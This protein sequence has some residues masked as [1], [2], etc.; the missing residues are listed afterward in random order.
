[1][2][3]NLVYVSQYSTIQ[4]SGPLFISAGPTVWWEGYT[5]GICLSVTSEITPDIRARACRC[6]SSST[7][8][9][10]IH[11]LWIELAFHILTDI[12]VFA[13]QST[14]Y[15]YLDS[16][17]C[18]F[19]EDFWPMTFA[20]LTGPQFFTTPQTP[21]ERFYR[22]SHVRL[23]AISSIVK[24]RR[25]SHLGNITTKEQKKTMLVSKRLSSR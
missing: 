16:L 13:C 22:T 5:A 4:L 18:I 19:V 8:W 24:L 17:S 9:L 10:V 12:F 23:P 14:H 25:M 2:Q 3:A 15:L 11:D 21:S 1:M 6:G 7:R 20:D